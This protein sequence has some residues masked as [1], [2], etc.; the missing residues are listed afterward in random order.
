ME[1]TTTTATLVQR[2]LRLQQ[3]QRN[4]AETES[5]EKNAFAA[6]ATAQEALHRSKRTAVA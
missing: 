2:N 4:I 1:S 5:A 3:A 6:V